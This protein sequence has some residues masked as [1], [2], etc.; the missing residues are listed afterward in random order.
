MN[1]GTFQHELNL[2]NSCFARPTI[3]PIHNAS[4]WWCCC[5]SCP[6]LELVADFSW[7]SKVSASFQVVPR[8]RSLPCVQAS[9]VRPLLCPRWWT[10]T[11]PLLPPL[12]FA[13]VPSTLHIRSSLVAFPSNSCL[14]SMGP[15]AAVRPTHSFR[16]QQGGGH[17]KR[18]WERS[19]NGSCRDRFVTHV[20][21][22]C[23]IASCMY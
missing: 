13:L 21:L 14:P 6:C 10:N 8:S 22:G 19:W 23:I 16:Q 9:V 17:S 11:L 18:E 15:R 20:V 2:R 4:C 5:G 1:A 7:P 12:S 3:P